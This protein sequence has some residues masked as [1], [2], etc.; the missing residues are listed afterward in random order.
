M[1]ITE[2]IAYLDG[3]AQTVT[4]LGIPTVSAGA[5]IADGL[6]KVI[7]SAM[8]AHSAVTGKPLDLTQLQPISKV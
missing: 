5:A 1:T 7:Q 3:T 4:A 6:L 2:I 8:S